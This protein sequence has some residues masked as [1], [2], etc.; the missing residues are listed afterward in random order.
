MISSPGLNPIASMETCSALVPLDTASAYGRR[1]NAAIS[2]SSRATKGPR[3][4]QVES[5][6]CITKSRSRSPNTGLA[7]GIDSSITVGASLGD[8]SGSRRDIQPSRAT[9]ISAQKSPAVTLQHV[10]DPGHVEGPH[11]MCVQKRKLFA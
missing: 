2:R 9:T 10:I 8:F 11:P 7:Q 6:A 4:I 1:Q 5:I 3:E